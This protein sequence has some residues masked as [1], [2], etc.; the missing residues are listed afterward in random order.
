[1]KELH[2][3]MATEAF[4]GGKDRLSFLASGEDPFQDGAAMR[5]PIFYG[6]EPAYSFQYRTLT[7]VKYE[8]DDDW[9]VKTRG[10]TIADALAVTKAISDF[11]SVAFLSS[12]GNANTGS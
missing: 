6:G 1:M 2:F 11:H 10:F 8:A 12:V 4:F 7:Q 5:E 3:A 9:L